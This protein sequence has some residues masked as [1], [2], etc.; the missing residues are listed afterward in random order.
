MAYDKPEEYDKR[1]L[2]SEAEGY[3]HD[4]WHPHLISKIKEL[5]SGRVILDAGCGSGEFTRHMR[6]AKLTIGLDSSLPMLA[7]GRKKLADRDALLIYGD[8]QR[9]PIRSG[10]VEA[11]FA[12]GSSPLCRYADISG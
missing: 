12:I 8:G 5:C 2:R 3:L 4:L 11:I 9:L 1:Y 10:V 7:R 6:E